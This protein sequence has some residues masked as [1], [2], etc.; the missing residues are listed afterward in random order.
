MKLS[1]RIKHGQGGEIK[2]FPQ[3]AKQP[4][5]M[6]GRVANVVAPTPRDSSMPRPTKDT[7]YKRKG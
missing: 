6:S 7:K 1:G 3:E 4:K 2:G 5:K